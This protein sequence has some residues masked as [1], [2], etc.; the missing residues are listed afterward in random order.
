MQLII[1]LKN[2]FIIPISRIR[3]FQIAVGNGL[4]LL[5][6]VAGTA[7]YNALSVFGSPVWET[8]LQGVLIS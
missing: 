4:F 2:A 5:P 8:F 1:D 7:V 6:I 3:F